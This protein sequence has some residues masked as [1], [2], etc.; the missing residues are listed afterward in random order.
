MP[1][2]VLMIAMGSPLTNALGIAGNVGSHRLTSQLPAAGAGAAGARSQSAD[3]FDWGAAGFGCPLADAD[4]VRASASLAC[5]ALRSAVSWSSWPC[6]SRNVCCA[7]VS[8]DTAASW[9]ACASTAAWS[10][11]CLASRAADSLLTC[12]VR[13]RC[14]LAMTCCAL[15]ARV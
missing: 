6:W 14:R 9:L 4:H 5:A 10:A 11:F 1:S 15:A 3:G 13:A 2:T 12:S 7:D 8:A